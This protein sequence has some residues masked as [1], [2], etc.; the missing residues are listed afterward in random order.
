MPRKKKIK[1]ITTASYEFKK[2]QLVTLNVSKNTQ[3]PLRLRASMIEEENT[4]GR[5]KMNHFSWPKG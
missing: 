4:P 5:N 2:V 1:T 3:V